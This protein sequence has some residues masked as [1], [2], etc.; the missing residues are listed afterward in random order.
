MNLHQR[1]HDLAQECFDPRKLNNLD[2]FDA[3]YDECKRVMHAN[4]MMC[5]EDPEDPACDLHKRADIL[6]SHPH[7]GRPF[8]FR[9]LRLSGSWRRKGVFALSSLLALS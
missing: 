8:R 6:H 2:D 4:G 3:L 7:Q 9:V 1:Y 5:P